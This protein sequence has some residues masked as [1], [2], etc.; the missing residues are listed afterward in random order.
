LKAIGEEPSET[1][2]LNTRAYLKSTLCKN[3]KAIVDELSE[4]V[5]CS[6]ASSPD[7]DVPIY[8]KSRAYLNGRLCKN[9]KAI[10]EELSE[11]VS[12]PTASSPDIEVPI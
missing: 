5:S 6:T 2:Y 8:L 4:M 1:V 12:G 11:I 9:L 3:L 10:G 7:I